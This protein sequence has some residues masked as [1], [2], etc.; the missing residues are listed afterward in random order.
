[1]VRWSDLGDSLKACPRLALR[2]DLW[3]QVLRRLFFSP[4]FVAYAIIGL[5]LLVAGQPDCSVGTSDAMDI[6][7]ATRNSGR[8]HRR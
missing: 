5:L 2:W 1:M 4:V 8:F 6:R 7:T 3:A